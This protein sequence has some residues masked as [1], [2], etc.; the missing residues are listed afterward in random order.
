[1]VKRKFWG[2]VILLSILVSGRLLSQEIEKLTFVERR[3]DGPIIGT[4]TV[5][6]IFAYYS[7][8]NVFLDGNFQVVLESVRLQ[9]GQWSEWEVMERSPARI[10]SLSLIYDILLRE[11]NMAPRSTVRRAF[12]YGFQTVRIMTIPSG[13]SSPMWWSED[14][15]SFNIFFEFWAIA[16]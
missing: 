11:Y 2:I 4:V 14:G 15:R 13:R 10:L 9:D 3:S 6:A 5:D 16:P 1:M 8:H 7:M 12:Q